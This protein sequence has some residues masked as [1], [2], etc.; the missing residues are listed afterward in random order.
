MTKPIA[1]LVSALGGEGGG[2]L[3][4]WLVAAA[5]ESGV[6]V[7]ATS[8]PGVAQ[9]TGSTTYYLEFVP[10]DAPGPTPVLSLYPAI[11]DVDLYAASELLEVGRAISN[12]FVTPDRTTVVVATHRIY[13]IAERAAMGDGRYDRD[14]LIGAASEMAKRLHLLDLQQAVRDSGAMVNAVLLG[15]IAA[16]GVL[17]IPQ[18]ALERAIASEGKATE[19]NLKGFRAG[20]ALLDAA[21]GAAPEPTAPAFD[22]SKLGTYPEAARETLALGYKRLVSYQ[23][24]AYARAFMERATRIRDAERAAGGDGALLD[25]AAR[26]LALWMAYEDVVRVAQ[27]KID[28]ARMAGVRADIGAKDDEPV[29]IVEFLKPGV[30]EI[31]AILPGFVARPLLAAADRGGWRDRGFAMP[32]RSTTIAGYALLRLLAALRPLRPLGHRFAEERERIEHWTGMVVRAAA[33]DLGLARAVAA[34]PGLLKGYGSTHRRGT[35]NY[36][37]IVGELVDPALAGRIAPGD[38]AR[39]IAAAT[40]A[41]LADPEGATL[42]KVLAAA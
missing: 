34:L 9:R 28:P 22:L 41:A 35:A 14:R 42:G 12:G 7:Q 32:I 13:T 24:E 29:E 21:P 5:N 16:T 1:L 30:D 27:L 39:R 18:E 20:L 17:P 15:A 4:D 8:I 38:A 10:K 26:R 6:A 3:A 23:D 36:V 25:E 40:K 11:G 37:R 33:L 31:C 2:V 19:T